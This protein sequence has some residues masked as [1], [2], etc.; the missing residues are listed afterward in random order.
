[1]EGQAGSESS[2]HDAASIFGQSDANE[3][4]S[5]GKTA[6]FCARHSASR[7]TVAIRH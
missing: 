7:L 6:L 1:L 4:K 3:A 2:E 5:A